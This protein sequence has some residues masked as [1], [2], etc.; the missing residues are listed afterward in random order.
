MEMTVWR[1]AQLFKLLDAFARKGKNCFVA[2]LF[3]SR[4]GTHY[5]VCFRHTTGC[6]NSARVSACQYMHIE[7]SQVEALLQTDDLPNSIRCEIDE[8]LELLK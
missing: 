2:E 1:Y 7:L 3:L 5:S 8:R 4:A 6:G